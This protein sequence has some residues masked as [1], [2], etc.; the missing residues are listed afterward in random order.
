MTFL[1]N[2]IKKNHFILLI[3]LKIVIFST[4][5]SINCDN[6]IFIMTTSGSLSMAETEVNT[7]KV[8]PITLHQMLFNLFYNEFI[9]NA[10]LPKSQPNNL[11]E[12]PQESPYWS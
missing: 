10:L 3:L 7:M 6:I 1:S 9:C 5:Q 11:V 12:F 2:E 4:F 8:K